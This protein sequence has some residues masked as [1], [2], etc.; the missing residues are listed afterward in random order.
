MTEEL[1]AFSRPSPCHRDAATHAQQMLTVIDWSFNT[2]PKRRHWYPSGD[3][4]VFAAPA[5]VLCAATSVMR[6]APIPLA[7]H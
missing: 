6:T 7:D 4:A 5:K 2:L 3:F 1:A